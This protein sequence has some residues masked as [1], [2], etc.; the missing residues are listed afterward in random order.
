MFAS[1]IL[2]FITPFNVLINNN[3]KLMMDTSSLWVTILSIFHDSGVFDKSNHSQE[4][5]APMRP[6]SAS[7]QTSSPPTAATISY[8]S[9]SSR[10]RKD[11]D[12][13]VSMEMHIASIIQDFAVGDTVT[14]KL[15]A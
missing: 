8:H 12:T 7:S 5:R 1:S 10:N 11:D 9:E 3:G 15:H 4:I 14:S 13:T 2:L 6:R